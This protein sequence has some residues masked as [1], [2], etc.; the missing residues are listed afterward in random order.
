MVTVLN[1]GITIL[2]IILLTLFIRSIYKRKAV[3][4]ESDLFTKPKTDA[5]LSSNA[6]PIVT[7]KEIGKNKWLHPTD[8]FGKMEKRVQH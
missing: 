1:L 3:N 4:K 6:T 2:G 5:F 8:Q 7:Q